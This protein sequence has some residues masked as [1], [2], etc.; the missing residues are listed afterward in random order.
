MSYRNQPTPL[1]LY[2]VATGYYTENFPQYPDG[3]SLA[4]LDR[5]EKTSPPSYFIHKEEPTAT[6]LSER[7][8]T[9]RKYTGGG[10]PGAKIRPMDTELIFDGVSI[11]VN[12][13]IRRYESAGKSDRAAARDLAEQI[14]PFVKGDLKAQVEA[15]SGYINADWEVL[16][17]QLLNRFGQG[18]PLVKPGTLNITRGMQ[19]QKEVPAPGAH[20]L[21]G[22]LEESQTAKLTTDKIGNTER[23]RSGNRVAGTVSAKKPQETK[24]LLSVKDDG[25]ACLAAISTPTDQKCEAPSPSNMTCA[26]NIVKVAAKASDSRFLEKPR[27]KEEPV[28]LHETGY[29]SDANKNKLKIASVFDCKALMMPDKFFWEPPSMGEID[30]EKRTIQSGTDPVTSTT[31]VA[32]ANLGV[33]PAQRNGPD[34]ADPPFAEESLITIENNSEI[35]LSVIGLGLNE[36]VRLFNKKIWRPPCPVLIKKIH[37]YAVTTSLVYPA[38]LTDSERGALLRGP[39][40]VT[41]TSNEDVIKVE[42][43]TLNPTT[44]AE[45]RQQALR[46]PCSI[47]KHLQND[48]NVSFAHPASLASSKPAALMNKAQDLPRSS[49]ILLFFFKRFIASHEPYLLACLIVSFFFFVIFVYNLNGAKHG[50]THATTRFIDQRWD[51]DAITLP[52]L[53]ISSGLLS[54]VKADYTTIIKTDWGDMGVLDLFNLGVLVHLL[55]DIIADWSA[56]MMTHLKEHVHKSLSAL[57]TEANNRTCWEHIGM[58]LKGATTCLTDPRGNK[59]GFAPYDLGLSVH[60]LSNIQ[61]DCSTIEKNNLD[62]NGKSAMLALI[63]AEA[64]QT[65]R[66]YTQRKQNETLIHKHWPYPYNQGGHRPP[67]SRLERMCRGLPID[68]KTGPNMKD[69]D[70]LED[71]PHLSYWSLAPTIKQ[72]VGTDPK[73]PGRTRPILFPPLG[74]LPMLA[75]ATNQSAH[76]PG[77]TIEEHMKRHKPPKNPKNIYK[78]P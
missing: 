8:L 16:K 77:Q 11:P 56:L 1:N 7:E 62:E 76:P 14:L 35:K 57:I 52:H 23:L 72:T 15:M 22:R 60:L 17:I 4:P 5:I 25:R 67:P 33:E 55:G 64:H 59:R 30:Q 31:A 75:T 48:S 73:K 28:L 70:R 32:S 37:W 74:P 10:N 2:D 66:K 39:Q 18:P 40:N 53:G 43:V 36:E 68:L 58:G 51:G 78:K 50:I 26:S 34:S 61:A 41:Q 19:A 6:H 63:N 24:E 49:R 65:R 71:T 12:K 21:L 45:D 47:D 44:E 46:Y 27:Q 29:K 3:S 38:T 54:D 20:S 13:F 69:T 42:R 9:M